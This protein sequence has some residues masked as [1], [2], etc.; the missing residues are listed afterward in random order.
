MKTVTCGIK[1]FDVHELL[2]HFVARRAGFYESAG[3]NVTLMDTSFIPDEKLPGTGFFQVACGAAL[4]SRTVRF[5]VALAAVTKPMFWL[6]AR[7]EI[8]TI[9]QLAGKRI[10]GYPPLAP[11][12]W[13]NRVA[14]R[15]H[16]LDPDVDVQLIPTRDD[17]LRL[18]LLQEG[19]AD[20]A[21]IRSALSPVTL[22]RQGVVPLTM[23]GDEITA[24]SSGIAVTEKTARE[25][26]ALLAGLVNAY[27][28]SLTAMR[29]MPELIHAILAEAMQISLDD[30]KKTAE[31]FLRCYTPDGYIETEKLQPGLAALRAEL[32]EENPI[33]TETLYDFKLLEK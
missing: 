10:A 17:A 15:K 21:L 27:R 3:L 31:L 4:L 12:Y 33:D 7:P 24:V 2:C 9:T 6:Y 13:F 1:A 23:L 16:G 26:P 20:A 19:A 22:Q 18:G 11:P 32:G 8:A 5:K 29:E 28:Q 14:L 25:E 30:A